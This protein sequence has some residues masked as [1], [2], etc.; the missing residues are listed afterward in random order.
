MTKKAK[1]L[2]KRELQALNT[3]DKILKT[4]LNLMIKHGYNSVTIRDICKAADVAIGTFYTYFKTKSDIFMVMYNRADEY[5]VSNVL[6]NIPD[7]TASDKINYFF[8]EYARYNE[9]TELDGVK[10][11]YNS[12]NK[13]FINKGRQMQ[14][15]LKSI[16][17]SC[18]E[19]GELTN[20]MSAEQITEWMFIAARG[21]VYDWCL[22]DG[23]YDLQKFMSDYF[24]VFIKPFVE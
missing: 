10:L 5:F 3:K 16:I 24:K 22:H 9:S 19:N 7:G 1:K 15:G 2:N 12:E 18:Q 23:K 4:A 21:V 11:L 17:L 20:A 14:E 13:W 8:I 6:G